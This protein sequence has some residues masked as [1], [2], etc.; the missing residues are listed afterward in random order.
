MKT[1]WIAAACAGAALLLAQQTDVLVKLTSS[2][3]PAV[4]VPDFRGSGDAQK[5]MDAFNQTLW[6][7]LQTSG[8]FRMVP[9]GM[10]PL[11][12]PQRPEDFRAP[13]PAPAPPPA[14]RGQVQ[15]PPQ[16]VSQ[17]PWLT[18]W[19]APP[20]NATYLAFGYTAL[21]NNQLVLF[22][23]FYNVTQA[24]LANAQLFGKV[25]LATPDEA[26]AR[27]NAHDFAA[28]IIS[29]L[30]GRTLAG[31][32]VYF[33]SDR[34]GHKEIWSM[35]PDG[36]NQRPITSYRSIS[37]TPAISPDGTKIAF[38]SFVRGNPGIFI[39]SVETGR[40]LPF[41]NQNASINA[42]PGFTPDGKQILFSSSLSGDPQIYIANVDGSQARRLTSTRSIEV[43]PKVNP[44]NG[45]EV[46]FTSGRS[47]V[48]QLYRMNIDG[49]DV[50]RLTSGEGH[51]VNADWHPDG[52]IIAFAWTRGHEPGFFN[53]FIMNVANGRF[54]QLTHGVGKNENPSWA[55][56]G[57]HLV[58]AS[59]RSGSTQIWT[60]LADG[61]QLKQ[62]T[63]QGRNQQPVWSK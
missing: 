10:Y 39:H 14:R 17:G 12:V 42:T 63:T 34:T 45:T 16:P 2:E 36:G 11:R 54:D 22:G 62:L 37:I 44:K 8:L 58:F 18:D 43:E 50:Q 23:W 51:A 38:T 49:A 9:K 5:F 47:G 59:N 19:S 21:Q 30:G 53:I 46:V 29:R 33:V 52:Q 1:V 48:P 7:D 15:P 3:R 61:T 55:P 60:M 35:D 27:K 32:R 4:A 28:D 24:D 25:Y 40:R 26:G 41:F 6:D 57:R 31:S 20:V 56:D 13:L